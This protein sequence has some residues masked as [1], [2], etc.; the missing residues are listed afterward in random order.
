MLA[1]YLC[2]PKDLRL[3]E[4]DIPAI[5]DNEMLMKV[6][7][8][9]ICG[10]DIRMYN[11]GYKGVSPENPLIPGHEL[12]GVIERVGPGI[13][14]YKPGMRIA[15]APNMGCGICDMCVGGNTQ[16]CPDY[17][18][19]GINLDGGFAEYVRIP[20]DA[21][22]QGNVI[23]LADNVSFDEAALNEPLSC[24][25]NGFLKCGIR[26]GD[27]VLIIGAGPIGIMHAKMARMAGAA[28]VML[29]DL[30]EER[31]EVCSRID[32]SFILLDSG[33][34]KER[35]MKLTDG[36]GLDVC[37]T[38][39]PSPQAQSD[40]LEMMAMNGRVNFFGGLPAEKEIVPI[41]TNLVHYKQLILTGSARSSLS[42]FRKTL[43][44]ISS[45]VLQ[46]KDLVSER[47]ALE[48]IAEGILRASRAQG[49][50]NIIR[51][52]G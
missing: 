34:L 47:F 52:E 32:A 24:V 29:N 18:A 3:R 50:K 19:L 23:E 27:H 37:I 8:A 15:V 13:K 40:S 41:N 14:A 22:R 9:A 44:F 10:T 43:G 36:K 30:S 5:H 48:D 25:Y 31:L 16:L 21:C 1:A 7:S 11:Y 51:F 49:I 39:C 17:R 28:K 33:N 20:E 26:P 38:A 35:V 45:G 12:S 4:T 6:K 2:G 46:V 42:Q